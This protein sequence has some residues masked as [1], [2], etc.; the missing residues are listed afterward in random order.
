LSPG[1]CD[2]GVQNNGTAVLHQRQ[3]FL[4]REEKAFHVD[5]EVQ[6]KVF[7]GDLA[8]ECHVAETGIGE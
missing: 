5:V 1:A 4:H 2:G 8:K 6:V 3:R 7:F